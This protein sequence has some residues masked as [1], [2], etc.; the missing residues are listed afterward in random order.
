MIP[1]RNPILL[2][3]NQRQHQQQQKHKRKNPVIVTKKRRV[4]RTK[5]QLTKSERQKFKMKEQQ[6][7]QKCKPTEMAL[8]QTHAF[9]FPISHFPL[10][11]TRF[12]TSSVLAEKSLILTG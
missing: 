8:K 3:K 6:R 5:G 9:M 4:G 7:K 10:T 1:V 2:L 11:M 12:A